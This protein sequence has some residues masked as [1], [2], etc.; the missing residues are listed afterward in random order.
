MLIRF[1][2][3]SGRHF[4]D[5]AK[6]DLLD[7]I[8]GS[9]SKHTFLIKD[10]K[11]F[12]YVGVKEEIPTFREA[13][14]VDIKVACQ[15]LAMKL[16]K[17]NLKFAAELLDTP[18][19]ADDAQIDEFIKKI[20]VPKSSPKIHQIREIKKK[21]NLYDKD[22]AEISV[23]WWE[24]KRDS[25]RDQMRELNISTPPSQGQSSFLSKVLEELHRRI[26]ESIKEYKNFPETRD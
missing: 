21:V 10:N 4:Y 24:A 1:I 18:I 20:G 25:L 9:G 2:L 7:Q 17:T 12:E 15:N 26:T 3:Q 6:D 19:E 11:R 14:I 8:K 23:L 16:V 22:N 5:K 13:S